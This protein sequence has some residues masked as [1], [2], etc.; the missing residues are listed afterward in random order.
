M[1][2]GLLSLSRRHVLGELYLKCEALTDEVPVFLQGE[3]NELIGSV[4]QS[5]GSYA[6]ALTFHLEEAV[7]K[8]LA[9]GQY[10]YEFDL[11]HG[12][13]RGKVILRAVILKERK[14][15]SKPLPSRRTTI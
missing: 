9:S 8:K 2:N 1:A 13:E 12:N 4:D 3:E 10:A 11:D 14:A 7:C 6:D 5:L 15:Y